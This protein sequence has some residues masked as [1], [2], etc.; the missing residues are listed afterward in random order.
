MDT[1]SKQFGA[2]QSHPW[3]SSTLPNCC[4]QAPHVFSGI[5]SSK[6]SLPDSIPSGISGQSAMTQ[7]KDCRG[8]REMG[9]HQPNR[10][11]LSKHM[12]QWRFAQTHSVQAPQRTAEYK[13][14]QIQHV[15][16]WR[17]NCWRSPTNPENSKQWPRK[18]GPTLCFQIAGLLGTVA[19]FS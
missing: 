13:D 8:A 2:I 7:R 19:W 3:S 16:D 1:I 15:S 18:T 9:P 5:S 4:M 14:N 11:E 12:E 17:V 10:L 6:P